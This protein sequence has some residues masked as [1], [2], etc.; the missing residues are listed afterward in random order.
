MKINST[1]LLLIVTTIAFAQKDSAFNYFPMG[2]NYLWKYITPTN[3]E[4]FVTIKK[5]QGNFQFVVNNYSFPKI[6]IDSISGNVGSPE[7]FNITFDNIR[8]IPG[9]TGKVHCDSIKIE[10]V[11]NDSIPVRYIE[12]KFHI[13]SSD[14]FSSHASAYGLGTIRGNENH[15]FAIGA[16][17]E[18][19]YAYI[20]GIHYGKP[21]NNKQQDSLLQYHRFKKGDTWIFRKRVYASFGILSDSTFLTREALGDTIIGGKR[22]YGFSM[23]NNNTKS[24][25]YD[26]LFYDSVNAN[27]Y[28]LGS[29]KHYIYDSLMCTTFT[30]SSLG[31]MFKISSSTSESLFGKQMSSRTINE[32]FGFDI[33]SSYKLVYGVGLAGFGEENNDGSG[34][35]NTLIYAKINGKEYGVNPQ[36][37]LQDSLLQFYPLQIG[38]RWIYKIDTTNLYVIETIQKDTIMNNNERY[39]LRVKEKKNLLSGALLSLGFFYERIDTNTLQLFNFS[40]VY[41]M[42]M[43]SL[44]SKKG[45]TSSFK[46]I[47]INSGTENIFGTERVFRTIK[48]PVLPFETILKYSHG[49]GITQRTENAYYDEYP[50]SLYSSSKYNIVYAKVNGME[51]GLNPLSVEK[52]HNTIPTT[53][54]LSQN[55]PNPFNP[56]TII[57][58]TIKEF[59]FVS[60]KIYDVV[61]REV[62]TLVREQLQPG[63]YSTEWNASTLP[64]GMYF[65]TI[66]SGTLQETKKAIVIK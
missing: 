36:K 45:D 23:Y 10:N 29:G 15:P 35:Y 3:E 61:G 60:L 4:Y 55:Y 14:Y 66:K 64:S 54:S 9:D 5:Y 48:I 49:I 57:R 21:L 37:Q 65:Y 22:Y 53:F 7:F 58:F 32:V 34:T 2:E 42:R 52:E 40:G 12:S 38:N 50:Y 51:F 6:I 59:G 27:V 43:D 47:Y 13:T 62:A 25:S 19:Q 8:I 30:R 46:T 24:I 11:F 1:I 16:P 33:Y 31:S 56:A 44:L 18:L 39:F 28:E 63:N 26:F 17:F 20:N 41:E